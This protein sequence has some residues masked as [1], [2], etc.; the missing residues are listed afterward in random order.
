MSQ[1]TLPTGLTESDISESIFRSGYFCSFL[2]SVLPKVRDFHDFVPAWIFSTLYLFLSSI[3]AQNPS[4]AFPKSGLQECD[5]HLMDLE[6]W[7]I[8]C[9]QRTCQV[10]VE[11]PTPDESTAVSLIFVLC[12]VNILFQGN[13]C[14]FNSSVSRSKLIPFLCVLSI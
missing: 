14:F 10:I 4:D 2:P 3:L 7:G 12:P 8:F 9:I 1:S 5:R 11:R 6:S 13:E